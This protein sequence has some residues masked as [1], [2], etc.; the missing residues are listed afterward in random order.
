MGV[1]EWEKGAGAGDVAD[2][3]ADAGWVEGGD[4]G[5]GGC[6]G[7]G[8]E[9][10]G[11]CEAAYAACGAYYGYERCCACVGVWGDA[12]GEGEVGVMGESCW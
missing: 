5:V 6:W 9:E 12:E 1:V 2:N 11:D 7:D 4:G 10:S 3:C 8:G